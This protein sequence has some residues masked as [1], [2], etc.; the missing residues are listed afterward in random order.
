MAYSTTNP[1]ILV[2]QGGIDNGLPAE[3]EY[4]SADSA[5]TVAVAGYITDG[6]FRGAKVNDRFNVTNTSTSPATVTKHLVV[7]ANTSTGALDLSD[8]TTEIASANAT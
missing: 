6:G 3:W 8:P 4:V 1:P 2:R 7:T 5:A